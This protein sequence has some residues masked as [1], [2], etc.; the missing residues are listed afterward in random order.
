MEDFI[1][2]Y[3]DIDLNIIYSDFL[4]QYYDDQTLIDHRTYI[5]DNNLGFGEKPFHVIWRELI[6]AQSNN[7]KFLEIGVYKGQI[8]SLVK[9]LSK[10][11][12]K[13]IEFYGVT[14]LIN[15]GD[16]FSNYDDVDY[17]ETI[18]NL[19]NNFNLEF[20]LNKNIIKGLSNNQDI[21]SKIK[22][23]GNFDLVYIDGGHDYTCVVSDILLMKDITNIGAYIVFDDSSCYKE[24]S[25]DKFKGHI[26]VCDAI[27]DYLENDNNYIEIICVGH[28]RVFK[29]IN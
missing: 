28:N 14:P 13:N 15:E 16:K 25:S 20:D 4:N 24:L 9:L 7:F 29:K 21:K 17:G 19:F 5:E 8:L 10:K 23:L 2:K 3:K 27:K 6:K 26:D 18:K 1:K 12:G 11:Y 22:N